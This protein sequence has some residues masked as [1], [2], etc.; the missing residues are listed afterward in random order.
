[1]IVVDTNVICYLF[2]PSQHKSLIDNLLR[3]DPDWVAPQLW[4]SEFRNALTGYLRHQIIPFEEALPIMA[5]AESFFHGRIF[6]VDSSQVLKL[7]NQSSCSAYDCEFVAL[8]QY[9]HVP[10]L[11]FDKK[12]LREFPDTAVS[13]Q[14]FLAK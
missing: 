11:T 2:L 8:A 4:I 14:Q 13:P 9:L 12:I 7:V 3:Y 10:L 1:M 6:K 5:Q